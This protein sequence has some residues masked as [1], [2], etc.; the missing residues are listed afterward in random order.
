MEIYNVETGLHR[1][2][3]LVFRRK[4]LSQEQAEDKATRHLKAACSVFATKC[5]EAARP[6]LDRNQL[7]SRG[8]AAIEKARREVVRWAHALP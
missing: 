2:M 1:S 3:V 4:G 7:M 8:P 5:R 6:S